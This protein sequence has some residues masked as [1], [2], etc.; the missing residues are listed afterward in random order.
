MVMVF[1]ADM[2]EMVPI[3][4]VPIKIHP[5]NKPTET[6]NSDPGLVL[7]IVR[8]IADRFGTPLC[9]SGHL[10]GSTTSAVGVEEYNPEF[11]GT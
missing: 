5:G 10:L 9:P 4:V 8:Q 11:T 2:S 3:S 1:D 7:P 6:R